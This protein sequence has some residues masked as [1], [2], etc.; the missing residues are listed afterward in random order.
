MSRGKATRAIHGRRDTA[1]RS[2]NYPIYHSTTFAVSRSADYARQD[3][4]DFFIYSRIG[5][6]TIRNVEEK[7]AALEEGEDA[8]L[9]AS[10]MAAITSTLLTFARSG[11]ALAASAQLYGVA[12]RFLRDVVPQFGIDV[13]FLDEDE[14]YNLKKYAPTARLVYFETPIN[15]TAHCLS[16]KGVVEAAR[17]AGAITIMDNTFASP[18]NQSPL[19]LGVDIAIHSATKYISGHSDVTAGV[20]IGRKEHMKRVRSMMILMGGCSNPA[21]AAL[22]DRSLKTLTMRVERHNQT[23]TALAL[24]FENEGRVR[25][26]HYPGLTSSPANAIAREQMSGF[27]GVLAIELESLEAA[28]RFC[29]ALKVALN[30]TSLGSVETLVSIPVL[31]SHQSMSRDELQTAGVT[32]GMVR[33]SVGMEDLEDLIADFRGA[34]AAL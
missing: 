17:E 27:G 33:I 19:S 22:I 24:F 23:A 4:D 5:N 26:V 13:H 3:E 28:R 34:L 12:Y 25:R 18:I 31:T 7:L 21:D 10:G 29:D 2:A 20:S 14:L 16:I 15:P 6:P 30:A 32:P 9:F 1:Y 11:D 8:V